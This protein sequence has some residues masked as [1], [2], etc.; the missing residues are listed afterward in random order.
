MADAIFP[1]LS[2]EQKA[3]DAW[4]AHIDELNKRNKE[5][6]V[7]NLREALAAVRADKARGR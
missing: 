4:Q 7:R 3:K 5:T 6:L 2:R 1:S